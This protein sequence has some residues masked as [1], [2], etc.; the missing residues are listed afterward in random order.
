[1]KITEERSFATDERTFKVCFSGADFISITEIA[2]KE[3]LTSM[4][5]KI[6]DELL[7]EFLAIHRVAIMR[8]IYIADV[9]SLVKEKAGDEMVRELLH[10]TRK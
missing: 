4:L 1:M 5:Q 3:L 8:E 10:G 9:I 2:L 6:T 7:K